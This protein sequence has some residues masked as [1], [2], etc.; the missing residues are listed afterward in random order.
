MAEVVRSLRR[1]ELG[2]RHIRYTRHMGYTRYI[3]YV[4][5][6]VN[7]AGQR[8]KVPEASVYVDVVGGSSKAS[9]CSV[10]WTFSPVRSSSLESSTDEAESPCV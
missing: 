5:G 10:A 1:R 9:A 4:L 3:R 6:G 2:T 8:G 7:S